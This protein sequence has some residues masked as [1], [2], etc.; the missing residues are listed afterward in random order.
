MPPLCTTESKGARVGGG[1][2]LCCAGGAALA[3]GGDLL[4]WLL[5]V[6]P[7][8]LPPPFHVMETRGINTCSRRR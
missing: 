8:R 2:C 7:P 1:G 6:G 5:Q 3:G 4:L